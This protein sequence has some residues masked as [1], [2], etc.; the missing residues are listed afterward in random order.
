[1]RTLPSDVSALF[2]AIFAGSF[3][4]CVLVPLAI[5][6]WRLAHT[7][8]V[9]A[10]AAA[11]QPGTI[12]GLLIGLIATTLML[13]V[14]GNSIQRTPAAILYPIIGIIDLLLLFFLCEHY[15]AAWI[16]RRRVHT[17]EAHLDEDRMASQN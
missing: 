10:R 8:L 1:M 3:V 2:L 6:Y 15:I 9:E 11:A 4:L 12:V 17:L 5:G 13:V 14:L 16:I 7:S